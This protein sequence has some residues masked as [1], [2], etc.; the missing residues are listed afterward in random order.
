[1]IIINKNYYVF[2]EYLNDELKEVTEKINEI[3]KENDYYEE[4]KYENNIIDYVN[5][6]L[7][8]VDVKDILEELREANKA[9][10]RIRNEQ[11]TD[12]MVREA[13]DSERFGDYKDSERK[14]NTSWQQCDTQT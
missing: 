14:G 11:G 4:Y 1:M 8:S 3:P 10:A 7:F 5:K 12:E 2:N 6:E 9:L 13:E